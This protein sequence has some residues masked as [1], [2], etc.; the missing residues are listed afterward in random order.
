MSTL[1]RVQMEIVK[2]ATR[3]EINWNPI[4]PVPGL[5]ICLMAMVA[6]L[7]QLLEATRPMS[8]ASFPVLTS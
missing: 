5:L 2:G 1:T 4:L 3:D 7:R 8:V 6:T